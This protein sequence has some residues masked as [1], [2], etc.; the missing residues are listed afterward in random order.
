MLSPRSPP[1]PHLRIACLGQTRHSPR[2]L[3]NSG[4]A[5]F[6]RCGFRHVTTALVSL[7]SGGSGGS[8]SD[9]PRPSYFQHH[10][11]HHDII[12]R[13]RQTQQV[14][15]KKTTTVIKL[16]DLPQ[17]L[18]APLEPAIPEPRAE[19]DEPAYPT[20]VLQARRNMQKFDNCVVLTRVGGF[21]EIYLE[22]AE[23]YGPLLN[24]KVAH[25]KTSAGPVSMVLFRASAVVSSVHV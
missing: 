15:S 23:E 19:D 6:G 22:Q 9:R 17:G 12:R 16:E 2:A 25:K 14:R 20:V 4:P 11:R 7:F 3:P 8:R 10:Y 5:T 13:L 18:I 21:Y 24:L 1:V